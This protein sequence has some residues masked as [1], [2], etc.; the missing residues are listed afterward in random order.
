MLGSVTANELDQM[1]A[2]MQTSRMNRVYQARHPEE[3]LPARVVAPKMTR[4]RKSTNHVE[5]SDE[6]PNDDEREDATAIDDQPSDAA[7]PLL[8]TEEAAEVPRSA[9]QTRP[10]VALMCP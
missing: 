7:N 1:T 3:V 6:E 4:K 9:S 10:F 8:A 5:G 2:S